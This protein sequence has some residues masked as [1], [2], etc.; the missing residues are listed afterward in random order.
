[1]N[2]YYIEK[3]AGIFGLNMYDEF[4][5]KI[6]DENISYP[7]KYRFTET[8]LQCCSSVDGWISHNLLL[9]EDMM[10]DD[11]MIIHIEK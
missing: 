9:L 2:L 3:L 6:K 5:L 11:Y 8:G 10:S 4:T 1:M 7:F